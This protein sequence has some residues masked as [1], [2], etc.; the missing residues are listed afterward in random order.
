M[1]HLGIL[2]AC[3]HY[4]RVAADASKLDAQ[5]RIWFEALGHDITRVSVFETYEGNTPGSVG[6]C[7]IW[8]VSGAALDWHPS[9]QDRRGDLFRF[10]RGV[11]A[12]GAPIF[13][14]YCGEH[15][16]HAAIGSPFA[17]SGFDGIPQF[18]AGVL[19][20][21]FSDYQAGFVNSGVDPRQ[22]R[23]GGG[24]M[25]LRRGAGSGRGRAELT[26]RSTTPIGRL[27]A[28]RAPP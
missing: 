13:G 12:V 9:C 21:V 28:W 23:G 3:E 25:S 17:A 10:L 20:Q 2:L 1:T 15:A 11:D 6:D 8:I 26:L 16:V 5:L 18:N 22:S 19:R 27:P 7:D 24:V 14:T 4:P